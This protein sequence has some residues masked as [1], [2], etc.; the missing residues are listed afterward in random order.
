MGRGSVNITTQ[1]GIETTPGTAVAA[2]RKFSGIGFDLAGVLETV[3]YRP[4][5]NRFNKVGVLNKVSSAGSYS[6]NHSYTESMYLCEGYIGTGAPAVI[7]TTGQKRIFTP[8]TTSIDPFKTFTIQTGDASAA[9]QAKYC[10]INS[11]QIALT[12]SGCTI[13]GNIFGQDL[14]PSAT[15]SASPTSI[16]LQPVS[17]NEW[18]AYLDSTFGALGTTLLTDCFSVTIALPEKFIPKYVANPALASFKEVVDKAVEPTMTLVMENN[19]QARGIFAAMKANNLP[20][21]YVRVQCLGP[22]IAGGSAV[23]TFLFDGAIKLKSGRELKDIDGVYGYEFV[24]EIVDDAA[25]GAP[26]AVTFIN[27]I[28]TE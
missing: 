14:D 16:P 6:G 9:E 18:A 7:G 20:T 10:V 8:A 2:N 26:Y 22:A 12:R 25:F 3:F 1:L 15:L 27:S 28:V 11:I 13:S 5:G 23:N 24:F 4:N 21:Q 19:S 17:A